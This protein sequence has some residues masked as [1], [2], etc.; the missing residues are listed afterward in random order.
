MLNRSYCKSENMLYV[1]YVHT[2]KPFMRYQRADISAITEDIIYNNTKNRLNGDWVMYDEA[3]GRHNQ[4]R[5]SR[6]EN[7]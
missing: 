7:V 5:H 3:K 1:R 4:M 6:L 2:L